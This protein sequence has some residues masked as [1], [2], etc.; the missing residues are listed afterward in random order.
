M[1]NRVSGR[2]GGRDQDAAIDWVAR[3][4]EIAPLLADAADRIERERGIPEP[5]VA[6][7]HEAQLFRLLLPRTCDGVELEPPVYL[8]V[9]EEIAKADASTAWCMGQGNGGSIAAAYLKPEV[10]RA[11]FGDKRAVAAS[12]PT[13]GK[14]VAVEGGYRVSGTWA[15]ASGM[16]HAAW[17]AGHCL[18]HKADG[19]ARLDGDGRPFERTM[20]FPKERARLTEIWDVLGLKGTGSDQFAV[21][22]L[23]VPAD[24]SYTREWAPDRRE[25]GPLYRF[26]NY[27]MFGVAFAAVALGIARAT[28]DAFVALARDKTPRGST[29]ALRDNALVQ[30][31]IGFNEARLQ[32]GRAFLLQML[33]DIWDVTAAGGS[34]TPEQRLR[35][36]MA[37]TYASHSAREVVDAAYYSAGATAIFAENPFERRFRDMHT[38]SQQVQAHASNFELVGQSLLGLQ[39][40]SKYL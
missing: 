23:F 11:I 4:R 30:F 31:Q 21:N 14:A 40:R 10:A 29:Q 3:A 2:P 25:T 19:S 16:K 8:Q 28:L 1:L 17:L 36:R 22:D 32:S 37:T 7:L 26:S 18:V 15:F 20:F 13:F 34:P 5:V 39:P 27:Q 6:A 38:V 35:L 12:G 9:I 24:Y 33:H